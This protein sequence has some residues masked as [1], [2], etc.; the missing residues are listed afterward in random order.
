M[1]VDSTNDLHKT[2]LMLE[3]EQ[4]KEEEESSGME[5]LTT[6]RGFRNRILSLILQCYD[7]GDNHVT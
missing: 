1:I 2:E 7:D 3:E 6:S 4:E 5:I